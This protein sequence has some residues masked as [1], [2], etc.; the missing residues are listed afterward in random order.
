MNVLVIG[1]GG[2]EHAL[3]H[4]VKKSTQLH[5]LYAIPG[6]PGIASLATCI[7]INPMDNQAIKEFALD[8]QIDLIIPGSEVYLENGISNIFKG[9]DIL[10][11]GPTKEAAQIESSKRF[12]KDLMKKYSIPTA[13][14]EVFH[15]YDQAMEYIISQ[16]TPIVIKY[17]GLAGG[18]GVVVAM[19]MEEAKEALQIMLKERRYGNNGVVIEEYLTGPEFS[20]MCF[21]HHNQIIP[22]PIAQDHKR[23]YN[24]DQGPNTGGMGIYS[25][26]PIIP[27]TIVDQAMDTIM[28]PIAQALVQEGTPFTGFLYGGL[29]LTQ[30]GP[31]VIEFNARFGDPEAE[32]ILPKLQTDI[33]SI[34]TNIM[35]HQ[36]IEVQWSY[37]YYVG[38]VLASEGYPLSYQ[39]GFEIQG[40]DTI[41]D[42]VFHMG[43]TITNNQLVTNG[44]RVLLVT[45]H[46]KTLPEA[47]HNAYQ[48]VQK[49]NCNQFIYRTDIGT[50]SL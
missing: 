24:F 1:S 9:T 41:T 8:K 46:A 22:M 7:D 10:V 38:V 36:P 37:D 49:I 19:T 3:C 14:Y 12:A 15:T 26:V 25:G 16:G 23:L 45:G 31:K 39:T 34:M 27:Q 17:D 2:R 29:M 44:G 42:L 40:L 30:K 50:K 21:V 11:F 6:N 18:K 4:A 5:N 48:N 28:K 33:I 32:V 43:T 35:N 13:T 20:L 47:I